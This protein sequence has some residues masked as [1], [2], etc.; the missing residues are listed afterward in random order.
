MRTSPRSLLS[1]LTLAF[2]LL[3]APV[4]AQSI[5]YNNGAPGATGD[6]IN[7]ARI[8]S[9]DFALASAVSVTR[10]RF[11]TA[12][13]TEVPSE[14]SGT[15]NWAILLDDAGT[16]GAILASGTANPIATPFSVI[17]TSTISQFDITI[18]ALLLGPGTYR[19]QLQDPLSEGTFYWARTAAVTGAPGY[20]A[21]TGPRLIDYSFEILGSTAV[22]P[23]PATVALLA[24]GLV[25]I[26]GTAAR[27]RTRSIV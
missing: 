16:P 27:R 17:G 19:L 10:I 20:D 22:V 23:E 7:A 14:Y 25:V 24:F 18:A 11:F 12:N 9:D 6:L 13:F 15:F 8:L 2:P 5:L 1:A 21:L 3:T 26:L 4:A